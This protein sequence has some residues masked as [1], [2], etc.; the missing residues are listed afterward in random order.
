MSTSEPERTTEKL[1]P[2]TESRKP[3]K[4]SVALDPTTQN[5]L[6]RLLRAHF[7]DL[8]D[9]PLPDRI[10]ALFEELERKEACSASRAK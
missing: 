2:A 6:G 1:E 8:V 3:R 5:T 4:A 7:A 9:E 10:T